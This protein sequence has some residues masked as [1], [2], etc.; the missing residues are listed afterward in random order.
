M[1]TLKFPNKRGVYINEGGGCTIWYT[2]GL[3]KGDPKKLKFCVVPLPD[4]TSFC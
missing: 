2:G 3:N 1:Q 4:S